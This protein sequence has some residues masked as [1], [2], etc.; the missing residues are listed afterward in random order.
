MI[1]FTS[2]QHFWHKNAIEYCKRPFSSVEEMNEALIERWNMN[3]RE[4]DRVY[5]LGDFALCGVEKAKEII[6]QLN[7]DKTLVLGNHDMQ[8]HKPAKWVK[9]G[10]DRTA[11]GMELIVD[12]QKFLLSHFPYRGGQVDKR[13]YEVQHEDAGGWLLHGHVHNEWRT[14]GKMINVGVD[15]WDFFPVSVPEILNLMQKQY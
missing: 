4:G 8:N 11:T 15:Q 3:V 12:E 5:V 2:D 13:T 1:W 9:M 7:G 6:S 14:F 10:F